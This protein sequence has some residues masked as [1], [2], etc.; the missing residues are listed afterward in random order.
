M[1]AKYTSLILTAICAA[2]F[3]PVRAET[4]AA[5]EAIKHPKDTIDQMRVNSNRKAV[6]QDVSKVEALQQKESYTKEWMGLA[7]GN[8]DKT[9]KSF[10]PDNEITKDARWKYEEAKKAYE[11]AKSDKARAE[12]GLAQ[13][14]QDL[15]RA[16]EATQQ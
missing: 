14:R 16:K 5:V 9:L 12:N 11:N 3:S 4:S 8:Y 6:K 1:N 7:Q 10:G 13:D 2:G 15:K